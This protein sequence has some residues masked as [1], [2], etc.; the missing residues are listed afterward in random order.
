VNFILT[1]AQRRLW[2]WSRGSF[3]TWLP[4]GD[5]PRK[6]RIETLDI[7]ADANILWFLSE[8]GQMSIP[9]VAE[10]LELINRVL[11][12][13]LILDDP[14]LVSP[15]YP[16]PVVIFYVLSRAAVWGRIAGLMPQRERIC[17]LAR[18]YKPLTYLDALCLGS[19]GCLWGDRE[20]AERHRSALDPDKFQPAPFFMGH[21]GLGT[22][23]WSFDLFARRKAFQFTFE[24]D[25]MQWAM[26]LWLE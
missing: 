26:R 11:E 21:F 5:I 20:L 25:A 4:Q 1:R 19:V 3:N 8:F 13:D 17:E 12:T 14:F 9:G 15:Y 2:P 18:L 6:P 24:C 23:H 16:Y 7:A 22:T 10:T